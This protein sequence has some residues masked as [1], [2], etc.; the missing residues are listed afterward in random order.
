MGPNGACRA[1][2]GL[3]ETGVEH[4]YLIYLSV[5][6]PVVG[7]PVNIVLGIGFHDGLGDEVAGIIKAPEQGRWPA[8][9]GGAI[10]HLHGAVDVELQVKNASAHVAEVIVYATCSPCRVEPR[11][12]E[13]V[14]IKCASLI[15]AG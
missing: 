7:G 9:V 1:T 10:A 2:G 14:V 3:S 12:V 5:A 13:H 6:I 11:Q 4:E 8:V 15:L